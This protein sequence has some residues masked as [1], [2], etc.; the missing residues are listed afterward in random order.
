M[1]TEISRRALLASTS[2]SLAAAQQPSKPNVL[3]FFPDQ[4]RACETGYNG[5][6]NIPTPNIDRFASQGM[7]FTNAL[8]TCPLCTPYRAMLQTGRWPALS[9][10]V[11]NWINMAATGQS[12]GDVFTRGGYE[13]GFIGK[14]HLAAGARAGS[15]KRGE[16]TQA[17]PEAEFVPPGPGRM[18]YQ[19]WAAFNFHANFSKAFYYRD[20]PER[21]I[22]PKYETDSE[23]D[24]AIDFLR[25]RTAA[26]KPFFLMVAPHPPH[27]PWRPE[28]TPAES[29]E[30]TPK[31]LYWRPN[32]KGRRDAATVDPRCY[33]AML[34]N[35]DDNF[36]RLMKYLE[37]FGL[38]ENTI[39]VF[40]SDHGEMMASHG[41][42]NKMVPYAE[43]VD[44]PLLVR[45]PEAHSRRLKI[46]RPVHAHR[47]SAHAG[48]LVRTGD[49]RAGEWHESVGPR[50]GPQSP[51]A[52]RRSHDELRLTLGLSGERHGMAG[53]ARDPDQ[54]IHLRPL[55]A[56]RRGAL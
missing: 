53:M 17:K 50:V 32:V 37:D 19:H 36:G 28:Q 23:T 30:R 12:M 54:A 25:S 40:T 10:G 45:W 1:S 2:A 11:M 22:M 21:L 5:G 51:R 31:S 26:S 42:Y 20:T 34:G 55:A 44:I 24:F 3:F 9:G 6:K 39:V 48:V 7:N 41:R 38:A 4:V 43:A 13:T 29:L 33:Y 14:W 16:P 35:V 47:S 8:S 27:P 46:G 49:S 18:G 15:L 56:R 52:R